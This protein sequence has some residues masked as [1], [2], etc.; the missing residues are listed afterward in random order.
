MDQTAA[1]GSP[2]STR[3]RRYLTAA[4]TG[5]VAAAGGSPQ[6]WALDPDADDSDTQI[7]RERLTARASTELVPISAMSTYRSGDLC[8][9]EVGPHACAVPLL[10]WVPPCEPRRRMGCDDARAQGGAPPDP[11]STPSPLACPATTQDDTTVPADR[12]EEHG[13]LRL[14]SKTSKASDVE[15]QRG[16]SPTT[17]Q[18]PPAAAPDGTEQYD[19][20]VAGLGDLA[21]EKRLCLQFAGLC[22]WV[23]AGA[24]TRM[25]PPAA[26]ASMPAPP[27]FTQAHQP[28]RTPP[29]PHTADEHLPAPAARCA[30]GAHRAAE[31]LP[32]AT[33]SEKGPAP[34]QEHPARAA[35]DHAQPLRP[36]KSLRCLAAAHL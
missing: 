24:G 21:P 1:P 28:S 16:A 34:R 9:L 13:G 12:D 15:C 33:P 10:L 11:T 23:G 2:S 4:A 27:P 8:D 3:R 25:Q 19:H 7:P 26:T 30:A 17:P 6:R 36:G 18:Q 35:P 22:A 20:H 14:P 32:P 29:P 5:P 31:A